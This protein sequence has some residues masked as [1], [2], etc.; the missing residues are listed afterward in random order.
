MGGKRFQV[1]VAAVKRASEA[2]GP[3]Q[4]RQPQKPRTMIP[5]PRRIHPPL[6]LRLPS[7]TC[8]ACGDW[9]LESAGELSWRTD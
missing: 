6:Q 1:L 9:P 3:A 4:T 5:R 2:A 7:R 8:W